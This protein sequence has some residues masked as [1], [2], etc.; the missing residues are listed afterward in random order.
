MSIPRR[1]TLISSLSVLW[2][3]SFTLAVGPLIFGGDTPTINQHVLIKDSH[4]FANADVE[5]ETLK[6]HSLKL[7]TFHPNITSYPP[8]GITKL[9]DQVKNAK[10]WAF[11]EQFLNEWSL[12]QHF[13]FNKFKG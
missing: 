13:K 3:V 6:N 7:L 11:L 8:E 4:Y 12:N 5:Y 9:L 2:T 10:S 1:R